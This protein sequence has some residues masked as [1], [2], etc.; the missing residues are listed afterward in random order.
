MPV[1]LELDASTN[2]TSS[3]NRHNIDRCKIKFL[4]LQMILS[5]AGAR[6]VCVAMVEKKRGIGWLSYLSRRR[7][8]PINVSL[9]GMFQESD[10]NSV[11]GQFSSSKSFRIHAQN[12]GVRLTDNEFWN[13]YPWLVM[14]KIVFM[15]TKEPCTKSL[16]FSLCH[17]WSQNFVA[18]WLLRLYASDCLS[19]FVRS[20]FNITRSW[21][22]CKLMV[23][24]AI[25]GNHSIGV[26][27]F[28]SQGVETLFS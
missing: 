23:R 25:L 4:L 1:F 28:L 20:V 3:T 19:G 15:H 8:C 26:A 17:K 6:D 22:V 13:S 27:L 14:S 5:A 18:N 11:H 24:P 2:K 16:I 10:G 12:T 21:A 9:L 7:I